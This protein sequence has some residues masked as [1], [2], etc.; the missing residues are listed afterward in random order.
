MADG[1]PESGRRF[2]IALAQGLGWGILS[3]MVILGGLVAIGGLQAGFPTTALLRQVFEAA[4]WAAM[5]ASLV[6][7]FPIGPVA[8]GLGWVAYRRRVRSPFAYAGIGALSA[9]VAPIIGLA[10]AEASMRY[11][12]TANVAVVR[13]DGPFILLAIFL[14]IGAFAGFMAGRVIRRDA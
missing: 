7:I 1:K 11:Q 14:A 12:P 10:I 8:G 3:A 4:M 5:G 13:E 9:A 2:A 6:A